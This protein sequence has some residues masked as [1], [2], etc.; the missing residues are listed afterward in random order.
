MVGRLTS[1]ALFTAVV[2]APTVVGAEGWDHFDNSQIFA[3]TSQVLGVSGCEYLILL[4][5][6]GQ[7]RHSD[8]PVVLLSD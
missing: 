8:C 2:S 1:I 5:A 7:H 4:P 3:G 6:D